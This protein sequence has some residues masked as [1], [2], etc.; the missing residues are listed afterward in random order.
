[1]PS[2]TLVGYSNLALYSAMAI[3]T[4]SMLLFASYLAAL[5]PAT[6]ERP[7]MGRRRDAELVG[8]GRAATASPPRAT[9]RADA[10]ADGRDTVSPRARRLAG[11]ALSMSW[12]AT[13]LLVASVAMRG[14][15]VMRPPWGNMF[16]FA[17][18]GCAAAALAYCLLARR[19]RWEWLGL[20]VI[21]P[22]LLTLGLAL[23][24][25]YTEAA[26]LMPALKSVWLVIHV[27]VAFLAVAV[28]TIG[29]SVGI[30]YLVKRRREEQ[31]PTRRNFVET[32]PSAA[33]LE[34][35]AYGL[36]MVGFILWTF[37][38]V[39]GAIWAQKAWS[40]YWTWDPKEVW[41]FVIWVV[42]AA[43]MHARATA[44]W[45]PRRAM[46]IA[47]AGYVCVLLNFT[48]VNLLFTGLHSYS[49]L[50]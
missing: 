45:E 21:G 39:A 49:G 22:I 47:L 7:A 27:V 14:L 46:V 50:K 13:F 8:A 28:F 4:V 35:T 19:N 12:L 2:T 10:P 6:S 30:V 44:G 18:A 34:R 15:A 1:M 38:L 32:L 23:F 29:F 36:N 16:E 20:F 43:Y 40:A 3:F 17:T 42:Y 5:G 48:V 37:T 33:A 9:P 25:F 41:T 26:E 24:A 31:P 11:I